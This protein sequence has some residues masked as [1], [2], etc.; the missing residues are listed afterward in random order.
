MVKLAISELFDTLCMVGTQHRTLALRIPKYFSI[1]ILGCPYIII[2]KTA[3]ICKTCHKKWQC[4]YTKF[5]HAVTRQIYNSYNSKKNQNSNDRV[6]EPN[7][8]LGS[9]IGGWFPRFD[10]LN[11]WSMLSD[12]MLQYASKESTTANKFPANCCFM[13]YTC[14]PVPASGT[15]I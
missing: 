4:T 8:D 10:P 15:C 11:E 9:N 13:A 12:V 14:S 3:N 5:N 6:F 2:S 1:K 7:A